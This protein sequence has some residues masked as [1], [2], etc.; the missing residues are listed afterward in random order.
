MTKTEFVRE[1]ARKLLE[2]GKFAFNAYSN[3]CYYKSPH[4]GAK[5]A[6]GQWIP[7]DLYPKI[8]EGNKASVVL[9]GNLEVS[10]FFDSLVPGAS[11]TFFDKVQTKLH[12]I[13]ACYND[14]LLTEDQAVEVMKETGL[15]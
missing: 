4:D 12:D 14:A 3:S 6:I 2:Q 9:N 10:K 5:C 13:L 15:L 7:D 11:G 8:L 1:T